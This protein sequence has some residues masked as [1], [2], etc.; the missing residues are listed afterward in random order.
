MKLIERLG[1]TTIGQLE[2]ALDNVSIEYQRIIRK[3]YALLFD[4]RTSL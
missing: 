2:A 4:I 3:H 1:L